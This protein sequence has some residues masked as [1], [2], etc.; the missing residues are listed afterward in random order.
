VF[1]VAS[2]GGNKRIEATPP[3]LLGHQPIFPDQ[4]KHAGAHHALIEAERLTRRMKLPSHT[5]PPCA[6]DREGTG[7]MSEFARSVCVARNSSI[8]ALTD[9]LVMN[10][11]AGESTRRKE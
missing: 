5:V 8:Q 10:F 9:R 7:A 4:A 11:R 2:A 6:R 1:E 3:L